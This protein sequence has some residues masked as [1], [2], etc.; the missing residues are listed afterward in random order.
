MVHYSTGTIGRFQIRRCKKENLTEDMKNDIILEKVE[1]FL[2]WDTTYDNAIK[3]IFLNNVIVY[4]GD[5]STKLHDLQPLNGKIR[6]IAFAIISIF[7]SV[8]SLLIS[9]ISFFL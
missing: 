3:K 6:N 1:P 8:V 7:I 2:A 5:G 9:I 4:I